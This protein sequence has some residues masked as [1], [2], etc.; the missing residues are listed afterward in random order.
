ML[1]PAVMDAAVDVLAELAGAV[2]RWNWA[3]GTGRI[4]LPLARRAVPV[5][6]TTSRGRCAPSRAA[7]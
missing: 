6:G 4:T 2:G 5:Y 3:I 7:A 1:V